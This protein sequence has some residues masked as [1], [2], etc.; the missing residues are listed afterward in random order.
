[1]NIN[2]F[3][4][5]KDVFIFWVIGMASSGMMS[6]VSLVCD[7][8]LI[9]LDDISL[10]RYL[11]IEDFSNLYISLSPFEKFHSWIKVFLRMRDNPFA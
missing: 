2:L 10:D 11:Y 7:N 6:D 1:M 5:E 4:M 9:L 3:C 8:I